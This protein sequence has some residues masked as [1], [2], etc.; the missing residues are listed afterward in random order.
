MGGRD[1]TA[2]HLSQ[3]Q[4]T[5]TRFTLTV[6][7]TAFLLLTGSISGYAE[8]RS[9]TREI[10]KALHQ[11]YGAMASR[12]VEALRDVLESTFIVVEAAGDRAKTHVINAADTAKLLPPEGN[13]DWQNLQVTDLKVSVTSTHPSVA[14][15]SYS[16]FHPLSARHLE[17]LEDVLKATPSPLEEAQR[18]EVSKRLE[19]KGSK[20]SEC[21]MLA[22]R[23]GRWRIVS[24][25]VPK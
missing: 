7:I 2:A 21:A 20:E 3:K 24:I 19:D 23:D 4:T 17:A 16:V 22:L 10:A 5:K 18:L 9:A 11:Y 6:A 1:V 14:T 8:E 13:D 12:D 15:V 25:S